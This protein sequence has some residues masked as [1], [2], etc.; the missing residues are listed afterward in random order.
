MTNVAIRIA[1]LDKRTDT[2]LLGHI[3]CIVRGRS[4]STFEIP[5][6]T[7]VAVVTG[8]WSA[9]VASS[10]KIYSTDALLGNIVVSD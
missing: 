3:K 2:R 1:S 7:T 10:L 9:R 6:R 5:E 8:Q 4:I